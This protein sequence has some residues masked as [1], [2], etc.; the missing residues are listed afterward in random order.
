MQYKQFL[1]DEFD[2]FS[3]IIIII[4]FFYSLSSEFFETKV[5][6]FFFKKTFHTTFFSSFS[7]SPATKQNKWKHKCR[8]VVIF[9]WK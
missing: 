7:F 5:F 8:R 9:H 4:Y 3:I 6:V 2:S 1:F